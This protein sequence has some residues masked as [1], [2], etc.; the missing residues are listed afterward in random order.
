M[1]ISTI[2]LY[3]KINGPCWV[4]N[5][6]RLCLFHLTFARFRGCEIML[7]NAF[8]PIN[9]HAPHSRQNYSFIY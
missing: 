5:Y 3:I 2:T 6:C 9:Y 1:F 4:D 7:S 8:F